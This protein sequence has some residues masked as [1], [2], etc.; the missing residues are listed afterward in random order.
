ME[1]C[2][3]SPKELIGIPFKFKT[4]ISKKIKIN[5]EIKSKLKIFILVFL[6]L[7]NELYNNTINKDINIYAAGTCFDKKAKPK[8]NGK[9]NQ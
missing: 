5:D 8:I 3:Q 6:S 4:K 7:K 2:Q 1:E 9:R